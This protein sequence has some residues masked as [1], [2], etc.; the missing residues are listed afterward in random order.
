[1]QA[2]PWPLIPHHEIPPL[3]AVR[4]TPTHEQ[5]NPPHPHNL[6][7]LKH[8]DG[9]GLQQQKET[10]PERPPQGDNTPAI[11]AAIPINRDIRGPGATQQGNILQLH[12]RGG[13]RR[14]TYAPLCHLLPST[15]RRGNQCWT[16]VIKTMASRAR[17]AWSDLRGDSAIPMT[18]TTTTA[19]MLRT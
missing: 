14:G 5:D 1:M 9:G 19:N 13:R 12:Q 6:P 8:R 18:P 17:K 10:I 7:T 3:H 15:T 4:E 16:P 2:T 11:T